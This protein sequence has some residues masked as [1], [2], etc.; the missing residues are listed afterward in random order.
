MSGER[1]DGSKERTRKLRCIS[2]QHE[3]N[4]RITDGPS[5][6]QY[7]GGSQASGGSGQQHISHLLDGSKPHGFRCQPKER[8]ELLQ[9]GVKDENDGGQDKHTQR[10][11][12]SQQ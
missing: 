9:P 6:S 8:I 3:G 2:G 4:E 12:R 10:Q 5:E 1:P 11:S 7:G